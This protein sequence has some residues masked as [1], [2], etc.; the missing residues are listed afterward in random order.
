VWD[1]YGIHHFQTR[2]LYKVHYYVMLYI[3]RGLKKGCVLD[4]EEQK[5]EISRVN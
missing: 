5:G 1:S 4:E 3:G 2:K